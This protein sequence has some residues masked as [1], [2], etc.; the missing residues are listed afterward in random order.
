M[1][2]LYPSPQLAPYLE[3][4]YFADP[5]ASQVGRTTRFTAVLTS[6]IK[7]SASAALLVGQTTH[8]VQ[9]AEEPASGLGI[10]LRAG[11]IQ[12]LFDI[13]AHEITNQVVELTDL[14]GSAANRL[15]EGVS[16]A[17]TRPDQ[18]TRLE[19][20]VLRLIK[21]AES[22]YRSEQAIVEAFRQDAALTISRLATEFG[23]GPRQLQRKLNEYVG[24]SPRLFKRLSRFEKALGL[25]QS[26]GEGENLKW[27]DIAGMCGYSD[28]AH[29][30]RE[31][32]KFAGITPAA[33]LRS[34]E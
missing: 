24:T 31:F 8:P 11:A 28:Q 29:F 7:I 9:V 4:Y 21:N 20:T 32:R 33:F 34:Q 17:Q 15:I 6:Y 10:K 23:Y 16:E 13:S 19:E 12:A 18:I 3:A 26:L 25:I 30:I 1:Q 14:W 27:V 2:V 5:D 22:E